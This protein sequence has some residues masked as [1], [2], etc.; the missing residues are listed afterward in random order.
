[1]GKSNSGNLIRMYFQENGCLG[2]WPFVKMASRKHAREPDWTAVPRLSTQLSRKLFFS[3]LQ[4]LS[5]AW[6]SKQKQAWKSSKATK[7]SL[8]LLEE[9]R[10]VNGGYGFRSPL[11]NPFSLACHRLAPQKEAIISIIT[12]SRRVKKAGERERESCCRLVYSDPVA[13]SQPDNS[14]SRANAGGCEE[15]GTLYLWHQFY[16]VLTPLSLS[17]STNSFHINHNLMIR[18]TSCASWSRLT[19]H[20]WLP[21]CSGSRKFEEWGASKSISALPPICSGRAFPRT[22]RKSIKNKF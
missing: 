4:S 14:N 20:D 3:V 11:S 5:Q 13:S 22:A 21:A 7:T 16:D 1:M 2:K 15:V 6:K 12:V 19:M 10:R 8:V 9:L 18:I 17:V